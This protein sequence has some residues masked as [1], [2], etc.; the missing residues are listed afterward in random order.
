MIIDCHGHYTTAPKALDVFRKAQIA[1]SRRIRAEPPP[2]SLQISD[3]QVR[4]TLEPAQLKLPARTRDGHLDLFPRRRQKWRIISA[5]SKP[6]AAL[7]TGLQRPDRA[8][9]AASTR[10]ASW[11]CANCPQ[12]P[13]CR[14]E[15]VH[16][17]A[18]NAASTSSALS[19]AISIQ[20]RRAGIGPTRPLTDRWVVSAL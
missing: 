17:R 4:E 12:S 10:R 13:G 2:E 19:A 7:V 16:F 3:D 6:A 1:A 14:A 11:A 18:R 5:R 8:G 20:I 9:F 15:D